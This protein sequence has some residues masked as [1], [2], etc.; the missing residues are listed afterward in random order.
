MP[1]VSIPGSVG[2]LDIFYS[3][4]TPTSPDATTMVSHLPVVLFLHSG[5]IAQQVFEAQFSDFDLRRFNLVTLDF[6]SFGRTKG[7]IGD[8]RYTPTES[9]VDVFQFM[10]A[11]H[12]PPCHIFGLSIGCSVA[13]ELTGAHPDRVLSLTLCSPLTPIEIQSDHVKEGRLEIH[14]YWINGTPSSKDASL[15]EE[16]V[17]D[18]VLGATQLLFNNKSDKLTNAIVASALAQAME[19]WT[20]SEAKIK[21]CHRS[22]ILWFCERTGPTREV[23]SKINCPVHIIHCSEDVGYSIDN[24]GELKEELLAAGVKLVELHEVPG[25]HYGNVG[26]ALYINPILRDA[27]LTGHDASTPPPTPLSPEHHSRMTTPFTEFLAKYGYCPQEDSDS[28]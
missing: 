5:Y 28:D 6:R 16:M 13:L 3:I 17:D 15:D 19:N 9:V 7:V 26:S 25:P 8:V 14:E 4:A 27:V 20:G 10:E 18:V 11:L 24:A 23:L 12:L 22:C 1:Y 21:E 2:P